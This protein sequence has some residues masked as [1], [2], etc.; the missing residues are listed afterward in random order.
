MLTKIEDIRLDYLKVN[1]NTMLLDVGCGRGTTLVPFSKLTKIAVGVD[2]N[3]NSLITAKAKDNDTSKALLVNGLADKLPFKEETF[4]VV[5]C[6]EMLEHVDKP[7]VTLKEL[8]KVLRPNGYLCLTVPNSRTEKLLSFINPKW[9]EICGHS[10]LFTALELNSLLSNA[11][12]KIFTQSGERFFY[13]YFWFFHCILRTTHDQTGRPLNNEWLTKLLYLF[14]RY[15]T[16]IP[17][18]S[19]IIEIGNKVLPK[20]TYIYCVKT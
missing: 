6:R 11:G 18:A 2:L 8:S 1:K 10:S 19:K 14:W 5:V 4:D 20:S 3:R 9:M 15:F 13:T 7:S 12:F 16:R 17:G